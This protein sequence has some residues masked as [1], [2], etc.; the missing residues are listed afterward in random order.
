MVDR[1]QKCGMV[2]SVTTQIIFPHMSDARAPAMDVQTAPQ[3]VG[4]AQSFQVF[5]SAILLTL[6]RTENTSPRSRDLGRASTDPSTATAR[7]H[8]Q[9]TGMSAEML[10]S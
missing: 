2:M 10:G 6:S 4:M 9:V 3:G 8:G 7:L 5:L 1:D